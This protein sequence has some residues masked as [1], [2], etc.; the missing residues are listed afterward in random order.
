MLFGVTRT[1]PV[2]YLAIALLLPLVAV[3]ASIVPA[4]RAVRIDP[5]AAMRGD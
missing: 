4:W 5:V 3:C 2:T 1:D